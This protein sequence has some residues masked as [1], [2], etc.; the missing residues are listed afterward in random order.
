MDAYIA[1]TP[2]HRTFLRSSRRL[3]GLTVDAQV[4]DVVPADSAVV[5]DD[6]PRPQCNGVPLEA[7]VSAGDAPQSIIA[8]YNRT[9]FTSNLFFSPTS[10]LAAAAVLLLFIFGAAP[11]SV[12]ST[13]AILC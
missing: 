5:Y 8:S 9:F 2:C 7:Y 4:H 13:S 12:I 11:A 6:V 10:L 1:D 3:V